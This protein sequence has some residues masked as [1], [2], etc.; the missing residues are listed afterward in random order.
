ML[1]AQATHKSSYFYYYLSVFVCVYT[2]I[3][4]CMCMCMWVQIYAP[5]REGQ[6]SKSFLTI[7]R[8]LVFSIFL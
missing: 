3:H 6:R 4:E 2:F 1:Y 7:F 8:S 5:A